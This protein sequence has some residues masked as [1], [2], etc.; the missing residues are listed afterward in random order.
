MLLT[1]IQF[2][3]LVCI[4]VCGFIANAVAWIARA[5]EMREYIAIKQNEAET[6]QAPPAKTPYQMAHECETTLYILRNMLNADGQNQL[7]QLMHYNARRMDVIKVYLNGRTIEP[8]WD[9]DKTEKS[10]TDL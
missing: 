6:E 8:I 1:D 2:L 4:I 7:A 5:A 3:A 10:D 9:R